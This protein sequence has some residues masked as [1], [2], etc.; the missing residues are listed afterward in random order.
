MW[1]VVGGGEDEGDVEPCGEGYD[2]GADEGPAA[3]LE[4]GDEGFGFGFGR[5][6]GGRWRGWWLLGLRF[7]GGEAGCPFCAE[8]GGESEVPGA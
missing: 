3:G 8:A 1:C 5:A 4:E 2:A 7:E 6:A